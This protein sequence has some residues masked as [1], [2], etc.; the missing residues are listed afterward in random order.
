MGMP[1]DT[2]IKR[3]AFGRGLALSIASARAGGAFALDGALRKLGGRGDEARLTREAQRFASSLGELKGSYVKIGQM[4]A[5]LGEHFLPAP[6]TTALHDLESDAKPLDWRHIRPVIV[7]ALGNRAD[8]LVI[9]PEALAAASLAQVHRAT[10]SDSE[11]SVVVKVQYPTVVDVLEE[12]FNAVVRMLRLAR[13]IPASRDFD[14]WL[15]LLRIQLMAEVDYPRERYMAEQVTQAVAQWRYTQRLAA[16]VLV[17]RYYAELCADGVLVMDYMA[18]E[19]LTASLVQRLS[20]HMRNALG[21]T[22]LQ[23]FF[24]ELFELGLMQADPNFGNYLIDPASG[25]LILLDFGS[26]IELDVAVRQA[27]ADTMIGGLE[28]NDALLMDGL[29]RL[30]C[31]RSDSS[32]YARDTFRGF[33]RHLLEP[34]RPPETLPNDYLNAEG[35]YCWATSGLL[36]RAGK[37]AANS[38]ASRHFSIPN[39]EFALIARKLT[40]V[41]TFIAMLEAEF[42]AWDVVATF[43][44]QREV[45][46]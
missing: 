41:F 11:A 32:D 18:G 21:K 42:N 10:V 1:K 28:G 37:K 14:S 4:F 2:P 38:A 35:Q 7:S 8:R 36:T 39:A 24:L 5:L 16:P 22:M 17:P 45:I 9:Q 40:G 3:G 27:L 15:S 31:L 13:W 46:Q 25:S 34:L 44:E 6:L 29:E 30:G 19:R 12:D 26:V 20:Q 23:L 43:I 33:I